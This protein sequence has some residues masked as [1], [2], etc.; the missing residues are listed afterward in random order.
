MPD[1]SA[2]NRRFSFGG[3]LSD[4]VDIAVW[5]FD[6]LVVLGNGKHVQRTCYVNLANRGDALCSFFASYPGGL[7]LGTGLPLTPAGA[8]SETGRSLAEGEV[9]LIDDPEFAP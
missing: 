3:Y 2:S 1:T 7:I 8:A 9:C 5:K 4:L 6:A